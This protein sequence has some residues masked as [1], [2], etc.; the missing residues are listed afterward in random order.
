MKIIYINGSPKKKFSASDYFIGVQKFFT[1][2]KSEKYK[3]RTKADGKNILSHIQSGDAVVFALPLY[4]D[5]VPSHILY[6]MKE[7]EEYLKSNG[8][9]ISVYVYANNGFIEGKQNE[10]L[11]QIF[12]NFCSRSNIKWGG[13]IGVGGGVML[14]VYR[15]VYV[16]QIALLLLNIVLSVVNTG[17]FIPQSALINFLEDT[18]ILIFLNIGVFL[19]SFLMAT[20]IRRREFFGKK[21]TRI[22]IPSFL[23]IIFADIFFVIISIL[24]GGIFKGWLKKKSLQ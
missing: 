23:F 24:Q 11:M 15:I 18:A 2:G 13:G 4:V 19:F 7:M 3:L 20:K 21:Y 8:I 9:H 5:G 17:S 6:F 14:N 10:P 22:M 12:E 1:G 16:V